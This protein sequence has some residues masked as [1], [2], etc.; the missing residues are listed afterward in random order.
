M[1][2]SLLAYWYIDIDGIFE[3]VAAITI[4]LIFIVVVNF[5]IIKNG[6]KNKLEEEKLKTYE[7]YL[8]SVD[9]TVKKLRKN[10]MSVTIIFKS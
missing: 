3:N 4:I 10:N 1:L 6:L 8:P 9:K 5:I 7:G 2:I